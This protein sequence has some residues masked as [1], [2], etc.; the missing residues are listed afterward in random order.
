VRVSPDGGLCA[1][2]EFGRSSNKNWSKEIKVYDTAT[3]QERASIKPG[4]DQNNF[5]MFRPDGKALATAGYNHDSNKP[6][7]TDMQVK[8][9]D[10]Q[11]GAEVAAAKGSIPLAFSP[12]GT[13]LAMEGENRQEV[14]LWDLASGA[15]RSLRH[16][17]HGLTAVAFS[18][19][20]SVLATAGSDGPPKTAGG[21]VTEATGET[22]KLWDV[23]GGDQLAALGGHKVTVTALAFSPD[24][25]LLA[26]AG[27]ESRL[28]PAD[29]DWV[30]EHSPG[31]QVFWTG[32]LIGGV[33]GLF[34][35]LLILFGWSF[36][37]KG[38][39]ASAA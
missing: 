37:R 20:G 13:T 8:L 12:A 23:A 19:D 22:I 39:R 24:G 36:L 21:V 33:F 11:T 25:E 18:P 27:S 32:L 10:L 1:G 38:R 30:A 4:Y 9:W 16:G 14:I 6:Y 5:L 28:D 15:K 31:R 35:T 3:G 7:G 17:H 29:R 26:S 34:L 2:D